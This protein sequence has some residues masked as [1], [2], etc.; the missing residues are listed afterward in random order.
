MKL[1]VLNS[2]KIAI[3]GFIIGLTE[4]IDLIK[5]NSPEIVPG[6]QSIKLHFVPF[7]YLIINQILAS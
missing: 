7:L 6:G 1:K 2:K 5:I 4:I 3:T